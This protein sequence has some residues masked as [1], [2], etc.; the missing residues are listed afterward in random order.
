[1]IKPRHPPPSPVTLVS[2]HIGRHVTLRKHRRNQQIRPKHILRINSMA[3]QITG[4]SQKRRPHERHALSR[5]PQRLLQNIWRQ[6]N[7]PLHAIPQHSRA[8]LPR[9]PRHPE[10]RRLMQTRLRREKPKLNPLLIQCRR[11][12]PLEP[13]D[14]RCSEDITAQHETQSSCSDAAIASKVL[15]QLPPQWTGYLCPPGAVLRAKR[16]P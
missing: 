10:R 4:G 6:Q 11:G 5:P 12:R 14:V 9:D 1:M 7:L 2:R 15:S 8:I 3:V 16:R 13:T